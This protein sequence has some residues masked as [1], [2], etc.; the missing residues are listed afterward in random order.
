M[1]SV[2]PLRT[3]SSQKARNLKNPF[4]RNK[5]KWPKANEAEERRKL[6]EHL[7]GLLQK[8]L[9]GSVVDKLNLFGE[10][11]YEE[12][13]NRYGE[14]TIREAVVRAKGR[15]EKEID[16]LV[17]SR[18]QLRKC[19]RKA[20]ESEKE[21]L[22]ALWDKIRRRLANL[23]RSK[24]IRRRR[25]RKEKEISSFFRNLFRYARGLLEEKT[26]GILD[27]SKEELQEYIRTQY[28]DPVRNKPLD[29]R[30][31]MVLNPQN[32]QSCSTYHHQSSARSGR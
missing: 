3:E 7:S 29:P 9:R 31:W 1:N 27:V 20:E 22:K 10:I 6:F 17:A 30:V 25:K 32:H 18:M 5:I 15:R 4:R 12:C 19:W 13:R 23:W 8:A 11:L 2:A 28:S 24:R 26:S 14:V 21:G 16:D